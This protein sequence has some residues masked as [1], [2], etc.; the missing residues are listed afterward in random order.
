LA[1]TCATS[2]YEYVD[3]AFLYTFGSGRVPRIDL[4]G[5]YFLA[6]SEDARIVAT[7]LW[8]NFLGGHSSA[9][10][11]PLGDAVLDVIDFDIEGGTNQHWDELAKYLSGYSKKGKTVYLR[12]TPQ[13]S[14]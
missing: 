8:N 11:R 3:I 10:P 7:Y 9:R 4:A 5:S 1:E 12:A 6:S 13:W 2:H 14:F